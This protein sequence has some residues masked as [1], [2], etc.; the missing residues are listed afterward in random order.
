M[1]YKTTIGAAVVAVVMGVATPAHAQFAVFDA[2]GLAEAAA[3][4]L[5]QA[6]LIINTADQI[7]YTLAQIELMQKNLNKLSVSDWRSLQSTYYQLQGAYYQAKYIGM[8]WERIADQYDR[9]YEKYDPKIHDGKTYQAKRKAWAAQTDD[10]IK[11]AMQTHGVVENYDERD[12]SLS[13]MLEASQDAPGILAAVQ[14]GNE[15]SAVI[16]RQ[17]ME[18]TKIIVADSRARLS[19]LKEQ[20]MVEDAS[21][22]QKTHTLMRGYGEGEPAAPVS[23]DI[24]RFK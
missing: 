4:A 14:A 19:Y 8:R 6:Q 9:L 10:S 21:R 11:N 5:K 12:V 24:P 17:L 7:E 13:K 16:A 18:L 20:Q 3:D 2:A 1:N 15:I 22:T 23:S